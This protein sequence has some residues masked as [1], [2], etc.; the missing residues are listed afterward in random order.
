MNFSRI[1]ILIDLFLIMVFNYFLTSSV[2]SSVFLSVIIWMGIYAFRVYDYDYLKDYN[3][4]LIRV[5]AGIVIGFIGILIF[6]PLMD[7]ILN[8][9]FFIYNLIILLLT[10][11]ILH[12]IE[13]LILIKNTSRKRYLVIGRKDELKDILQEIEKKTQGKVIFSEFL[14]PSPAV[15][16]S[17]IAQYDAVLV[18]DQE[19]EKYVKNQLNELKEKYEIEYLPNLVEKILKR[20]PIEVAIKFKDYYEIAF[21]NTKESPAKRILDIFGSILGLIIFSPFMLITA[22]AILIED[23]RP[24]IFKQL[25]VGEKGR[26]FTLIKIRS[27]KE[28]AVDPE[29]PNKAIEQRPL[30]IGKIIRKVRLDEVPQ[31]LNVL[32]GDMSVVGPRPEMIEFHRRMNKQIPFYNYRLNLKPGITGWAQINYKHTT[33]LEDYKIK[34]EYDLYYIKNRNIFLDLKILLQT[35]E[36]ILGMRGAK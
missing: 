14:N 21:Q 23:G 6:Y 35:L 36:T 19:L 7:K 15:L 26:Y 28:G 24:V 9:W 8:R 4:Q 22:I 29:N 13:Y 16:K 32:K 1:I 18:A 34:T 20:I 27:L 33:T 10:I 12:K 5:F 3:E 11:P 2:F 25:R 17:K 30:K 31:F